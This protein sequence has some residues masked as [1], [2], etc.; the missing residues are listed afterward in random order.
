MDNDIVSIPTQQQPETEAQ[1]KPA[2]ISKNLHKINTY[3]IAVAILSI[4]AIL[5]APGLFAMAFIFAAAD[6]VFKTDPIFVTV[7]LAYIF[8]CF[9]SSIILIVLGLIL[10][11]NGQN[12]KKLKR[13]CI[14]MTILSVFSPLVLVL[15]IVV[16]PFIFGRWLP[17]YESELSHR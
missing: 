7:F 17:A 13:I 14:W 10:D 12:I 4:P 8:M 16:A 15:T 6:G 2:Q 11:K 1:P 9:V 5:Y 3:G